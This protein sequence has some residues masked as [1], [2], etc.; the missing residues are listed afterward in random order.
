MGSKA[1][2][3]VLAASFVVGGYAAWRALKQKEQEPENV[4]WVYAPV[5]ETGNAQAKLAALDGGQVDRGGKPYTNALINWGVDTLFGA[6]DG[7]KWENPFDGLFG[8]KDA[9]NDNRAPDEDRAP[10]F[11]GQLIDAIAGAVTGGFTEVVDAGPGYT[12]VRRADGS[13]VRRDGTRAWRNNNPG[14]IEYGAFA[15]AHGAVGTDGRFAVFPTYEAGRRAKEA[16][17]FESSSYR[18]RSIL[19]A[20]NR[21]APPHENDTNRYARTVADAVGVPLTTPITDLSP[22]QRQRMLDAMERVEG[23]RVGSERG[24]NV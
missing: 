3:A 6:L 19:G 18:G 13:V 10:S 17:L 9:A 24:V 2:G 7:K 20:I 8:R 23:F 5:Y 11:G 4:K 16:L 12:V 22:A 15:K 14:N 1:A 21:Y